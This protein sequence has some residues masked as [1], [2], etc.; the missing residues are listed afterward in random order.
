MIGRGDYSIRDVKMSNGTLVLGQQYT[1]WENGRLIMIDFKGDDVYNTGNMID[2]SNHWRWNSDIANRNGVNWTT[3][4]VSPSLRQN[5]ERIYSVSPWVDTDGSLF[6]A[7]AGED[8][9]GVVKIDV[10][11]RL[12]S[13]V[14]SVTG[15]DVGDTDLDDE[16]YRNV[17]FDRLGI[18]WFSIGSRLYRNTGAF[19]ERVVV[20]DL[21]GTKSIT[22]LHR[23]VE[24]PG[25]IYGLAEAQNFI[26]CAV[27]GRV[28]GI[29]AVHRG[30]MRYHLA[31]T[32]AGGGGIGTREI[33]G[34]GELFKDKG[35]PKVKG[36]R[37]FSLSQSNFLA[38]CTDLPSGDG[39]AE[40][41][42][43]R[44]TDDHVPAFFQYPAL[45]EGRP[46]FHEII[47]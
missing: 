31:Y 7:Y 37:S 3:S 21:Y 33:A 27:D 20:A 15:P 24:L 18:L 19:K 1:G 29:Y 45:A 35:Y 34:I 42:L 2:S 26:F 39:D 4:G 46:L 28:P 8:D 38:I 30:S 44:T 10:T 17:M 41:T 36:L 5:N 23:G 11:T 6:V 9:N 13:W 40:A 22:D 32:P 25:S 47:I 16:L 14:A 12:P 43:I